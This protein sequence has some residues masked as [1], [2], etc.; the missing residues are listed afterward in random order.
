MSPEAAKD[1][2][3]IRLLTFK[4]V[5]IVTKITDMLQKKGELAVFDADGK[6]I[7]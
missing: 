4:T 1:K 2:G 7:K 5:A 3:E 6:P